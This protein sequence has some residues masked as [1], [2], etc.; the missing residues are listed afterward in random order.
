M[1]T[2][3]FKNNIS[4]AAEICCHHMKFQACE[5]ILQSKFFLTMT[6]SNWSHFIEQ[7]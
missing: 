7:F 5:Y 1:N 2:E 6:M 3:P 4:L